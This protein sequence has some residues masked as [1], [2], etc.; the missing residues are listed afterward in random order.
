[1]DLPFE[2]NRIFYDFHTV[3]SETRGNHANRN[4]RFAFVSLA[5]SCTVEVDDG[6]HRESFVLDDP[7]KL[8]CVDRMTWKVMRDFTPDNVLLV[9][10]D[11]HYDSG[12]YI[13]DYE[14]FQRLCRQAREGEAI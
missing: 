7:H 12:E 13:R 4:S 3:G 2:I 9:L 10:S 11:C 6:L 5:G 8:L 1:M 14:E